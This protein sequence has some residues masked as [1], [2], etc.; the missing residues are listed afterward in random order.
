MLLISMQL[1]GVLKI[2]L[3]EDEVWQEEAQNMFLFALL[4]TLRNVNISSLFGKGKLEN[5]TVK[6]VL[7]LNTNTKTIP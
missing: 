2:F 5:Y 4:G 3:C 7:L 1:K 6:K